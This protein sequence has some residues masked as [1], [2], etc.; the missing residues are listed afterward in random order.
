[1]AEHTRQG[2]GERPHKD[3]QEPRPHHE[4]SAERG[5]GKRH[6]SS[7]PDGAEGAYESE[8]TRDGKKGG[9]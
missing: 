6:E 1:M 9:E 7:R 8:E 4:A 5:D 2:T 3:S